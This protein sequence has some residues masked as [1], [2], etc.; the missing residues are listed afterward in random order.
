[1]SGKDIVF[2][3]CHEAGVKLFETL[4]ERN[5]PISHVVALSPEQGQRYE[6]AGYFDFGPLAKDH[7]VS[8]YTPGNYSL[9]TPDDKAFFAER[10][11][12]GEPVG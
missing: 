10:L 11:E 1:M 4:V 2:C 7:G 3:G 9:S 8:V 5:Q 12:E 6:I